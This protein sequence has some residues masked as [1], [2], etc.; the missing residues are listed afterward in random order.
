LEALERLSQ[1]LKE[2]IG[3]PNLNGFDLRQRILGRTMSNPE[4]EAIRGQYVR[5]NMFN[6]TWIPAI[7]AGGYT[8]YQLFDLQKDPGQKTDLA[9][10]LPD[11]LAR[12]KKKLLEINA[13]VMADAPEWK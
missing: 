8:R 11:V 2:I 12:L 7:K 1:T 6:E 13:S 4:H 10:Q 9:N 5:H 3:D